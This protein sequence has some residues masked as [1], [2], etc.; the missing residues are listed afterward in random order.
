M[1]LP[2]KLIYGFSRQKKRW[3][4]K[5][6]GRYKILVFNDDEKYIYYDNRKMLAKRIKKYFRNR[7][8]RVNIIDS[9]WKNGI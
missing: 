9:K 3:A 4:E 1:K 2:E 5:N 7:D 6:I 8:Y